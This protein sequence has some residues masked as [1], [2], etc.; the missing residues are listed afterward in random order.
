MAHP[1]ATVPT[2]QAAP[3]G[4]ASKVA[5]LLDKLVKLWAADNTRSLGVRLETG[6]L[7]NAHLG[8]PTERQR[9]GRSVLKQAADRLQI[10]ESDLNRMRWL[11]YFSKDESCWG[12]I[13]P[14]NRSWS[15][16][17]AILPDLIAALKGNER[18]K[19]ISSDEKSNAVVNGILRSIGS[20]TSKLGAGNL[21]VDG[22]KKTELIRGLQDLVS[23]VS[24]VT[25]IRF[26]WETK[27]DET[28]GAKQLP[29][30]F[31]V[32]PKCQ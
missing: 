28:G 11:P 19:R 24:R 31:C 15:K 7:L 16:F 9:C 12:E 20:A 1:D 18:R 14:E 3:N 25:G 4:S 8:Q 30:G 23:A 5:R 13:P 32:P 26:N 6:S 2:V 10:A 17:K 21:T 29:Y 22:P 27:E